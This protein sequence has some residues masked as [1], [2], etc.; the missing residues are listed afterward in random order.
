MNYFIKATPNK[1][2]LYLTNDIT[3]KGDRVLFG[4]T[5]EADVVFS[6]LASRD[7]DVK[8]DGNLLILGNS[9]KLKEGENWY[10]EFY[11]YEYEIIQKTEGVTSPSSLYDNNCFRQ[12][13]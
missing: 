12:V 1:D 13:Y 7:L 2:Q 3:P 5:E 10:I 9:L 4:N 8:R 6:F 11:V